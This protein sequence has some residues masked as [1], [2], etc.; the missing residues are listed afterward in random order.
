MMTSGRK[1]P[2]QA[3][4]RQ[5][6]IDLNRDYI[7]VV[8]EALTSRITTGNLIRGQPQVATNVRVSD[9]TVRNRLHQVQRHSRIP[10]RSPNHKAALLTA[11]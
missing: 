3:L 9:Q 1:G 8:L 7:Y 6:W 2:G 4:A 10:I 11:H 5:L